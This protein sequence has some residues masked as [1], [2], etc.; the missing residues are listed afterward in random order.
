MNNVANY[1]IYQ[2][3]ILGLKIWL[4]K[5]LD[6]NHVGVALDLTAFFGMNIQDFKNEYIV[7][8]EYSGFQKNE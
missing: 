4:C 8:N 6:K 2:C 3:K 5:K 1:A 7:L